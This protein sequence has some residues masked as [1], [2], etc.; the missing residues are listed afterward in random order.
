MFSQKILDSFMGS[1]PTWLSLDV[2]ALDASVIKATGTPV[3][4]GLSMEQVQK[5]MNAVLP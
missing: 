5:V 2:D 1:N 4:G 3:D